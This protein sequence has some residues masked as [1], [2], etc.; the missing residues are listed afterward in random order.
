MSENTVQKRTSPSTV[1][2]ILRGY[3]QCPTLTHDDLLLVCRWYDK[4]FNKP[5]TYKFNGEHELDGYA[6]EWILRFNSKGLYRFMS[7]MTKSGRELWI[8]ALQEAM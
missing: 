8:E 1:A 7:H 3:E 6:L 5:M 2:T 4:A